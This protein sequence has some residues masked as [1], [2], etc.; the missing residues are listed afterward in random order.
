MERPY[1]AV[2]GGIYED[3]PDPAKLDGLKKVAPALYEDLIDGEPACEVA[4]RAVYRMESNPTFDAGIGSFQQTDGIAR[5]DAACMSGT[6]LSVGAVISVTGALHPISIARALR[7]DGRTACILAG[8]QAVEYARR[9]EVDDAFKGEAGQS[10]AGDARQ[11]WGDTVGAIALDMEGGIA[12]AIST[13]GTPN[14]PPGRVGDV[15]LI[16]CGAYADDELGAACFTGVGEHI[17]RACSA[18]YTTRELSDHC[19]QAAIENTL[20]EGRRRIPEY[21]GGGM[22]LSRAGE[23]GFA[24]CRSYLYLVTVSRGGMFIANASDH[25]R[26]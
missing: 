26:M 9:E 16:G 6:D 11:E 23:A 13:G 24:G 17:L 20:R 22:V 21:R 18:F 2:H 12:V 25:C 7:L 8:Q 14:A 4:C 10:K 5:M 3:E 1:L 19:P 15:P